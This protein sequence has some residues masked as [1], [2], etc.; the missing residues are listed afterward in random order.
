V[1]EPELR[2][3]LFGY[4]HQIVQ[5]TGLD[6][7]FSCRPLFCVSLRVCREPTPLPH[8]LQV[9]KPATM[10]VPPRIQ[11]A[12][13]PPPL[14][15][16]LVE[17]RK[18]RAGNHVDPSTEALE[19]DLADL[20]VERQSGEWNVA[21]NCRR[22]ELMNE[23]AEDVAIEA[24]VLSMEQQEREVRA[25]AAKEARRA[26]KEAKNAERKAKE[27]NERKEK[28]AGEQ[29]QPLADTELAGPSSKKSISGS[30]NNSPSPRTGD[31][32]VALL[33][34]GG[35][36]VDQAIPL[37]PGLL[38]EQEEVEAE[39]AIPLPLFLANAAA[40]SAAPVA[41]GQALPRS[42]P[43]NGIDDGKETKTGQV[44]VLGKKPRWPRNRTSRR[45]GKREREREE[46]SREEADGVGARQ[47]ASETHA[48]P[49]AAAA[50]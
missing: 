3:L 35:N 16:A 21:S 2:Q 22:G 42:L 17:H 45:L 38:Q 36:G 26:R 31:G 14:F 12:L 9:V 20:A 13:G 49:A 33:N 40:T 23:V 34:D 1:P 4:C 37:P 30:E 24:E 44:A 25:A 18:P 39:E 7:L 8:L 46:K 6:V 19:K 11:H 15:A 47:A 10:I 29:E 5:V 50:P 48:V 41:D 43:V 28:P 32:I 27:G